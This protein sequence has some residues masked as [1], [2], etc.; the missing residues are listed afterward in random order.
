MQRLLGDAPGIPREFPTYSRPIQR[1]FRNYFGLVFTITRMWAKATTPG[2]FIA[3]PPK[4]EEMYH[5]ETFGR[6]A[7]ERVVVGNRVHI[8]RLKGLNP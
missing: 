1:L 6:G 5:P 4:A 2:E 7:S 3:P 8:E